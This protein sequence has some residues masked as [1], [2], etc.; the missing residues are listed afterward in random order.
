MLRE[1]CVLT[2]PRLTNSR[3]PISGLVRPSTT[4]SDDNRCL[5]AATLGNP[6]SIK[7]QVVMAAMLR[8]R[9]TDSAA[10]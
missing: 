7:S 6:D 9:T 1:R 2:V 5:E 3:L 10:L 4:E 8:M